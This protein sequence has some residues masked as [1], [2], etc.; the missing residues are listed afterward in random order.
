MNEMPIFYVQ[1]NT[2]SATKQ[3][4][5]VLTKTRKQKTLNN[6][7]N[8]LK[9]NFFMQASSLHYFVIEVE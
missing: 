3:V 6:T 2:L 5:K 8:I 1:R 9:A 4:T 7:K